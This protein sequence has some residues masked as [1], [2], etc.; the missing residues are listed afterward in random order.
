MRVSHIRN[1]Y[2][3]LA[4]VSPIWAMGPT[5]MKGGDISYVTYA[6]DTSRFQYIIDG[7][8]SPTQNFVVAF[9][10]PSA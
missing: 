2:H 9:L 10:I 3:P 1:Y 6:I 5:S 7:L 8:I 4:T